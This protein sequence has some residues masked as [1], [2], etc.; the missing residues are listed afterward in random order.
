LYIYNFPRCVWR[1]SDMAI[2]Q[3]SV[4]GRTSDVRSPGHAPAPAH[5]QTP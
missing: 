4:F 5:A 2:P 1:F 3:A